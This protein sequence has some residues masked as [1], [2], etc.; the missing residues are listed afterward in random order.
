MGSSFS[1]QQMESWLKTVEVK[2]GKV[3]DVG[4]S[5]N[6]LSSKRLKTFE[7]EDYKILDLE[8]PHECK[9]V[10]DFPEDIQEINFEQYNKD[11]LGYFDTAFCLE[12]AEYW[13]NPLQ[14]LKNI[15]TFL[16][17]GGLFYSSWH[18]IYPM[19]NL[20]EEDCLRYTRFG[21]IKLL[22]KAGFKI[23]EITPRITENFDLNTLYAIEGMRP[24]KSF[25]H[26]NSEIGY[27]I[28][29]RKK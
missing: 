25:E 23:E 19:H 2:G 21:C 4:G 29:A 11:W 15:N 5:Q 18:F 22:E 3:L 27:L 20:I 16:K 1:R 14:A 6:P 28:N 13:W 26:H 9:R 24:A 8:V 7:P 17:K 10:P 12:V